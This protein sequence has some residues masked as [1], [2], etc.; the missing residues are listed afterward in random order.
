MASG[1][2]RVD[3]VAELPAD[4]LAPR[5]R[6]Q[7]PGAQVFPLAICALASLGLLG[8]IFLPWFGLSPT[9]PGIPSYSAV[10]QELVPPLSS[11]D[12]V[13]GTQKWGYLLLACAALLASSSLIALIACIRGRS[14][15]DGG[16]GRLLLC[17]AIAS[18][19][20]I[21]LVVVGSEGHGRLR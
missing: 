15:I 17:V 14:H 1:R 11:P 19:A 2:T 20:I 12:L 18:S 8:D 5:M 21:A 10:S 9:S 6:V 13:P 16:P 4:R 7:G 3:S